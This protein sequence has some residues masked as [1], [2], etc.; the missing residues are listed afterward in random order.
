MSSVAERH[1]Q[2]LE[3]YRAPMHPLPRKHEDA[4]RRG[5]VRRD[6]R[7]M[8]SARQLFDDWDRQ[9][10]GIWR[11]DDERVLIR[12]TTEMPGVSPDMID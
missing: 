12:C 5:V 4:I 1:V 6:F 2:D 11:S 9:D 3:K 8:C 7:R 10:D